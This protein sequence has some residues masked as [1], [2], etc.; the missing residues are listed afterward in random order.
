MS[1][2]I[3]GGGGDRVPRFIRYFYSFPAGMTRDAVLRL[4]RGAQRIEY[5]NPPFV[6]SSYTRDGQTYSFLLSNGMNSWLYQ[7][8][9]NGEPL[10]TGE[11]RM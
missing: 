11:I 4:L 1:V 5:N 10:G 8:G 3:G 2:G 6:L 9:Y 7:N